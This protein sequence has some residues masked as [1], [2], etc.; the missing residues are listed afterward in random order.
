MGAR[1]WTVHN[2]DGRGVLGE[3]RCGLRPTGR[4]WSA[5]LA[6][7]LERPSLP[8]VLADGVGDGPRGG[9]RMGCEAL[10][11]KWVFPGIDFRMETDL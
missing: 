4:R 6:A 10:G 11:P 8:A 9:R 5:R 3:P 1:E 2:Q 7:I